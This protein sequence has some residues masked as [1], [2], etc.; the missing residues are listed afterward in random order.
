MLERRVDFAA[1]TEGLSGKRHEAERG[2]SVVS[3]GALGT[4]FALSQG[5][6]FQT[7]AN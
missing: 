6:T 2:P 7:A 5:Q 1:E 3:C 4:H